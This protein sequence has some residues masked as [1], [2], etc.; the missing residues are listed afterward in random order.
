[1]KWTNIIKCLRACAFFLMLGLSTI[2]VA[3][4]SESSGDRLF[5][6]GIELQKKR[7][8]KAQR[9]AIEKFRSAKKLYDSAANKK[10]CDD[11][12]VVSNNILKGLTDDT[13]HSSPAKT[14][15]SKPAAS[16]DNLS[17]SSQ[18]LQI[19]SES[20]TVTVTVRTQEPQWTVTPVANEG[21]ESFV[22]VTPYPDEQRFDITCP[23]NG[24]TQKRS[25]YVKVSAGDQMKTVWIEQSGRPTILSMSKNVIT[26]STMGGSRSVEVY[27]NS[28]DIEEDN[29]NRNWRVYY[30]PSW[31][32]V[33]GA[34]KK[35]DGF[36]RK[37]AS[38]ARKLVEKEASAASD[39]TVV[40]SVMKIV[41]SSKPY[42]SQSRSGEIIIKSGDQ[43]AK[44][45]VQQD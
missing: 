32:S 43:Q 23:E 29:N 10:K 11:A 40:T 27:S 45:I 28:D 2:L 42:G 44:I 8:E 22:T 35:E 31:I 12:I 18:K 38:K 21:G 1:M 16:R 41:A 39:S 20:R 3:Q 17:L 19:D 9:Q 5:N 30:K 25:Q 7:T 15:I 33:I 37:L 6:Q 26:F 24:S 13:H 36:L 4:G 34:E 14:T